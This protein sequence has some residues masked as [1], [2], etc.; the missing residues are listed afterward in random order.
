MYLSITAKYIQTCLH[1]MFLEINPFQV[2]AI[3]VQ[4]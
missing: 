4:F 3:N 1:V 2:C